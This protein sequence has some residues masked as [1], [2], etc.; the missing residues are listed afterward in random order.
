M[1]RIEGFVFVIPALLAPVLPERIVIGLL[2]IILL[3]F[4]A[5]YGSKIKLKITDVDDETS[6]FNALLLSSI[7]FSSTVIGIPKS[8]VSAAMFVLAAHELRRDAV[9]NIAL[10]TVFGFAYFL[11]Y[12]YATS[13]LFNLDYLFFLSLIGALTAALVESVNVDSDKR[14]TLLLAV[15]TV[16]LIFNIYALQTSMLDLAVAF[17]VS[18]ILSLAATKAGVADESGLMS[19]TLI[20]TLVIVFTDIRFFIVLLSFYLIGSVATKYKYSLK[21][22]RGV[23][24]P[25]G[26]ARGYA[27]VFGNSFASLFFAFC[28]AVYQNEIF[29]IAFVASVATALGDTMASEI[30]KTAEKV[31]LITNF[32][33]VKPG[34]SGGISLKGETAATLGSLATILIALLLRVI[35][36]NGAAIAFVTS[37]V[38]I[39]IDSL[40]GAT[41]EEKGW[42]TNS[43]VNFFAT[44][45]SGTICLMLGYGGSLV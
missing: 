4:S 1:R 39:H 18:F 30:G 21:L 25:A 28:Y 29:L 24:E 8:A 2:L 38:A 20:G 45:S 17:A 35:D 16:Y 11:Y 10:Y 6:I 40:L 19:A 44:L 15:A 33:L 3:V 41:L 5:I 12:A 43:G 22:T 13:E 36:V 37:I 27:N 32:K 26:G 7:M 31:Y 14:V 42:L 9:W 34:V 23:A